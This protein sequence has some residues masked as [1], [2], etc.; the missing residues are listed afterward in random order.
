MGDGTDPRLPSVTNSVTDSR[1]GTAIQVGVNNG[2]ITVNAPGARLRAVLRQQEF[3]DGLGDFKKNLIGDRVPFVS[4]GDDHPAHPARIFAKLRASDE[5][6]VLLV[7]PAGTGKTRTGVEV[8]HEALRAGWRVLHVMPGEG[9]GVLDELIGEVFAEASPVLVVVDYLNESQLDLVGLRHRLLPEVRRNHAKLA[10]LAS[11]RPGWLLRADRAQLHELFDEVELRQDESFQRLVTENALRN[12]APT[13]VARLGMARMVEV[14]RRRPVIALLVAREIERRVTAGISLPETAA[15]RSGGDLSPWLHSRLREDNLTVPGRENHFRPARASAEL[16]AAAAA[17]AACPQALPEVTAAAHACLVAA[18]D[19]ASEAEHVVAALLSFGWLEEDGGLV[20]VAHD[21]VADQLAESVLLPEGGASPDV[22]RTR[23]LLA[24]CLTEPRTV[25]RFAVNLGRLVGDL[26]LAGRAAA[27]TAALDEWFTDHAQDLGQV[28]RRSPDVGG[29][30]LGALCSGAPWSGSAVRCWEQVVTP[31]L[32][33]HGDR[34]DARHLLYRGLRHL[35]PAGALLLVPTALSWLRAH[36]RKREASY[37]LAS[38]AS[39]SELPPETV[40]ALVARTLRWLSRHSPTPDARFVLGSLL[41]RSDLAPADNARVIAAA[42][43]WTGHHPTTPDTRFVLGSLLDRAD[44]DPQDAR[45]AVSAALVWLEHHPT[46]PDARHVL[47]RLLSR[48]DLDP[49]DGERAI[50]AALAWLDVHRTSLDARSVLRPLLTRPARGSHAGPHAVGSA[51]A[52]L[53]EATAPDGAGAPASADPSRPAPAMLRYDVAIRTP[54]SPPAPPG[55]AVHEV[56]VPWTFE[57]PCEPKSATVDALRASGLTLADAA[58]KI[59]FIAPPGVRAL[60]VFAA[61]AGFAHRW[62]DVLADGDVLGLADHRPEGVGDPVRPDAHLPWAQVGG[63]PVEG[64]PTVAFPS[65]PDSWPDDTTAGTLRYAARL[66]MVP[67]E[68]PSAALRLLVKLTAL[69]TRGANWRLPVLSTGGEPLPTDKSTRDQGL[70][71]EAIRQAAKA[72][73][74]EL[75]RGT[76]T[77]EVVPPPAVSPFDRRIAEANATDAVALL[78]RLG[79][80]SDDGSRWTCPRDPGGQGQHV[81]KVRGVSLV[82]CKSCYPQKVGL[83][84]LTMDALRLTPDEAAAFILDDGERFPAPGMAVTARVAAVL[85]DAYRCTVHDPVTGQA[86]DAVLPAGEF[87]DLRRARPDLGPAVGDTFVALV[88]N[89]DEAALL[90]GPPAVTGGA[91]VLSLTATAL[92]ERVLAG[93]VPELAAGE[94]AVMGTARVPGARTRVAVAATRPANSV[95][96]AFI[97]VGAERMDG[98]QRLL[99][100]GVTDEEVEIVPYSGDRRTMLANALVY[101]QPTDILIDGLRAVV[102]VPRPQY[103]AAVGRGGL[104]AQL[105]GQLTGLYVKVVPSGIDL[106]QAMEHGFDDE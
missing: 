32:R 95:R 49:Q 104:N 51:L 101:A 10:V 34:T 62:V 67:P 26:E 97:G 54:H 96:G 105:A 39:R 23:A 37:V 56:E 30:A 63:A 57:E 80:V 92:V 42:L 47:R 8:G 74:K 40:R 106:A 7:G 85:P 61:L 91:H 83:V 17:A 58:S 75:V 19:T 44:L 43:A 50:A 33:D 36:G 11:V 70:D 1:V 100:G 79:A 28:L 71:L 68:S 29:Y 15:L 98:F 86:H 99:T 81:L 25:G 59:V 53:R 2:S 48:A 64:M 88:L 78:R 103:R 9:R 82:A 102:A 35:S 27:V 12:L 14:S 87:D 41:A 38:L 22:D 89:A 77:V 31:W 3:V 84:R 93:F 73:R 52:W 94:V 65:D 60:P 72:Y 18:G 69:R 55:L 46:S 21:V 6:G 66:R 20:A 76:E 16:A 4:P 90:A 24:G 5:R 13:A 45:R